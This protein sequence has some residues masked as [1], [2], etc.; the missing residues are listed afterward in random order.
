MET[1]SNVDNRVYDSINDMLNGT[2][3][4]LMTPGSAKKIKIPEYD[5]GSVSDIMNYY[6]SAG[7]IVKASIMLES[8]KRSYTLEFINPHHT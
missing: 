6:R 5:Y 3:W 8:G 4:Q 1:C 2:K 7:W